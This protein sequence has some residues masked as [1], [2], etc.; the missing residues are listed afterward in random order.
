MD[1]WRGIDL[2]NWDRDVSVDRLVSLRD[3]HGMR[4]AIVGC[5]VGA[6]G[7]NYTAAQ[8][9]NSE[10]AGLWVPFT[11]EF[12]W[13][14]GDSIVNSL[15]RMR[16]A[17]TFGRVV[18]P[19]IEAPPGL[20]HPTGAAGMVALMHQ[21]KDMLVAVGLFWGWYSSPSEW[22]RLTG[23]TQ[24][25]AG[26]LCWSAT[27]P[28]KNLPPEDFMPDW[29]QYPA[30]GGLVPV[31]WQYADKCYDE[32][33]FDMNAML[34]PVTPPPGPPDTGPVDG[35]GVHYAKGF[36]QQTWPTMGPIEAD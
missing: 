23:D 15:T 25:F 31:V 33:T 30:F 32:P 14:A 18:A 1:L 6:D 20:S 13:Y 21:V 16:H 35:V 12:P 19:D 9:A 22:R 34:A 24:D 10:A 3:N 7:N 5:Q 8:V 26:D 11:Y 29:T 17:M 2:D 36:H 27:Y 28:Y 4:F